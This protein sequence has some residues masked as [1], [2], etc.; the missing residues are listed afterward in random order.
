MLDFT[1][2]QGLINDYAG[3]EKKRKIIFDGEIYMLKFPDPIRGKKLDLSYANHQYSEYIGCHVA[4]SLG[5][6]AQDTL[7]GTYVVNGKTKICV[8]CR[9]FYNDGLK[10][11]E[12]SDI[13]NSIVTTDVK[14]STH[15]EDVYSVINEADF[16]KDK[17]SFIDGFW[18]I[19][20]L[21]AIIGNKDRH[22]DNWGLVEDD[23]G[24]V[25]IAPVYDCGSCLFPLYSE[26]KMKELYNDERELKSVSYNVAS[27]YRFNGKRVF[28]YDIPNLDIPDLQRAVIR[29]GSNFDLDE[30][31][32]ILDETPALSNEYKEVCLRSMEIRYNYFIKDLV[33]ENQI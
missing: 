26:E 27:A 1:N 5:L 16:I 19:F 30:I 28:Y 7:L 8:A 29:V 17:Q 9:D 14:Y 15:I 20:V 24:K 25:S 22:F 4:R 21:D 13:V 2:C 10:L 12:F 11:Y 33:K 32:R 31:R 6:K 3:S 23:S 18:D